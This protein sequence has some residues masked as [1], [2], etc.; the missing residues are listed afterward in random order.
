MGFNC[1]QAH[2]DVADFADA[3]QFV[4]FLKLMIVIT[5]LL[6]PITHLAESRLEVQTTNRK[7]PCMLGF[8]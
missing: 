1:S 6:E 5:L 2:R 8:D 4:K 3:E 7:N